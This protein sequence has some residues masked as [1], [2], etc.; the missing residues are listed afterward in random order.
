[1]RAR[2]KGTETA[3]ACEA[4]NIWIRLERREKMGNGWG[5]LMGAG[6]GG[7]PKSS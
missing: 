1:M 7:A 4:T 2:V 3:K 6:P 5:S